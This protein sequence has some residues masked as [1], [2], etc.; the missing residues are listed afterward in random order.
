MTTLKDDVKIE[1]DEDLELED[2]EEANEEAL[3]DEEEDEEE[4]DLPPASEV[5]KQ[6][7]EGVKGVNDMAK[8]IKGMVSQTINGFTQ[9]INKMN[10]TMTDDMIK[11]SYKSF[12]AELHNATRV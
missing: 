2:V 8:G 11:S 10:K 12:K 5:V 1:E 3:D 7:R 6:V 4:F 9:P